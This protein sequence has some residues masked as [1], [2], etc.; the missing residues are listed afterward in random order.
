MQITIKCNS[1]DTIFK[2]ADLK[3]KVVIT[4]L[5]NGNKIE[6]T[7]IVAKKETTCYPG[8][9]YSTLELV[10]YIDIIEE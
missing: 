7:M 9:F 1:D 3:D 2:D 4:I 6:E 10:D 8:I 5:K